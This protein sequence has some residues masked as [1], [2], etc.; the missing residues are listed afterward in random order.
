MTARKAEFVKFKCAPVVLISGGAGVLGR[1]VTKLLLSTYKAIKIIC[2]DNLDF[3]KEEDIREFLSDKRYTF[4]KYDLNCGIPKGVDKVDCILHLAAAQTHV[5][6]SSELSLNSLLTNAF[7]T[8][9]LL[10][11]AK[12]TNALFL[13]ASSINVYQGVM[14][15]LNL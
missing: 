11:L 1:S 15:S 2:I 6:D 14:S 12:D 4:I 10:E 13:M 5:D 9:N 8:K 7:A 3:G